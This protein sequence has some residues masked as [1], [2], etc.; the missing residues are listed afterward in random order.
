MTITMTHDEWMTLSYA[1]RAYSFVLHPRAHDTPTTCADLA[2][3]VR[4]SYSQ[5]NPT[6]ASVV[7]VLE[8]FGHLPLELRERGNTYWQ[9]ATA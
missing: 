5:K 6:N 2:A 9:L 4:K 8:K 7:A 3:A 1:V